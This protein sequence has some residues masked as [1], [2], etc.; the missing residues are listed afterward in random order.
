[1]MLSILLL[2]LYEMLNLTESFRSPTSLR[3]HFRGITALFAA[4]KDVNVTNLD[5]GKVIQIPA[6]SPLSL[7]CVRADMRLSFQCKAGTC[8]SCVGAP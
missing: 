5:N 6:G 4:T 2:C 8:G 7:A 3:N 1:M